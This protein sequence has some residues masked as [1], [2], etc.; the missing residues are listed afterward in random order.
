MTGYRNSLVLSPNL[1][2]HNWSV[3]V[4]TTKKGNAAKAKDGNDHS[5]PRAAS[6]VLE[7]PLLRFEFLKVPGKIQEVRL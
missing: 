1:A 6:G 3:G 5:L 4:T 7:S 2:R